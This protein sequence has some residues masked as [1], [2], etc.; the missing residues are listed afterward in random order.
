MSSSDAAIIRQAFEARRPEFQERNREMDDAYGAVRAALKA[1]PL[2]LDLVKESF[3]GIL[4]ARHDM[5][6]TVQET[7]IDAAP[8]LTPEGR[9]AIF[10]PPPEHH[11][12]PSGG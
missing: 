7:I 3:N 2:D 4:T 5:T 1:E 6:Q 12:P 9:E 11:G 10:P 8:K